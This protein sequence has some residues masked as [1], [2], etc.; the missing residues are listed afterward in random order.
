VSFDA[1]ANGGVPPYA[2]LWTTGDGTSNSNATFTH[3]Y[4][5]LG[6]YTATLTV[7]DAGGHSERFTWT[8]VVTAPAT[9][10]TSPGAPLLFYAAL[11]VG[12]VVLAILG[13]VILRL[14]SERPRPPTP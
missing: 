7:R 3:T 13:F 12:L 1:Y 6:S 14:R 11:G 5:T 2:F 4:A 9:V 8:I 10:T